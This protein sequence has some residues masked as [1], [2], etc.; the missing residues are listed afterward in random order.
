[1]KQNKKIEKI[2][3][4]YLPTL[5]T[6]LMFVAYVPLLKLL[7]IDDITE[8]QSVAFWIMLSTV[9]LTNVIRE[10]YLYKKEGTFGGLLTQGGNFM[11]ALAVLVKILF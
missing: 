1:M 6:I 4:D 8:G 5:A 2:I 11:L 9:L 7:Y 3:L 10:A